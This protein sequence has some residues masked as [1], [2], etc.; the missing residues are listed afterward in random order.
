M[1]TQVEESSFTLFIIADNNKANYWTHQLWRLVVLSRPL[2][3]RHSVCSPVCP[4][5]FS[6]VISSTFSDTFYPSFGYKNR[7]IDTRMSI[8]ISYFEWKTLILKFLPDFDQCRP[9]KIYK[10]AIKNLFQLLG[11]S[12]NH[13]NWQVDAEKYFKKLIRSRILRLK[14]FFA[15][16]EKKSQIISDMFKENHKE[17]IF[18]GRIGKKIRTSP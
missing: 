17:K 10:Y 15:F 9:K 1:A 5:G 18:K 8:L 2:S 7:N 13:E 14:S 11:M 4:F 16:W 6:T 12:Y 3:V